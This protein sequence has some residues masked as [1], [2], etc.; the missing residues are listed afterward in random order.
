MTVAIRV[1]GPDS[2]AAVKLPNYVENVY[3]LLD[4]DGDF[5]AGSKEIALTLQDDVWQGT[6]TIESATAYFTF[7][8]V[9]MAGGI[10]FAP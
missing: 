8:S 4:D 1:P 6:F 10:S 3:L 7:A 9:S 2:S 5:S